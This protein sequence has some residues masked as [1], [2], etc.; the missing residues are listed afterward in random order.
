MT[1]LPLSGLTII[2]LSRVL[3]GPYCSMM[4]ADLG[5]RIIKVEQPGKGDDTRTYGPFSAS[6][7]SGYFTSINRG[8][9]SIALDLKNPDDRAVL[10]A[11]LA[12]ADVLL[13]NFRPG[14]MEKLGLGWG[15]LHARFPRLIY[16][17][18]SGFGHSGPDSQKAAYDVVAQGLSG[19]M[20]ITGHPG[21][22][23]T[24]VGTSIGDISAGMFACSGVL[25]AL[26][27][28]HKSGQG[29][30]VDVAMLDGQIAVLESAI[31]RYM[32]TGTSPTPLGTH[33][34]GITP[35]GAFAC[36]D[37]HIIIAA[38]N[39]ELWQCL[40][41]ALGQPQ[42]IND[43]KL[44]SNP[45]R[46][47]D[48]LAVAAL[49]ESVLSTNSRA[50][51]LAVLAKAGVPCAPINSVAEAVAMPQVQA[52]NMIVNTAF[53]DGTRLRIAGSPIKFS[54]CPDAL[55][56]P[57][58]AKLNEHGAAIRASLKAPEAALDTNF[59]RLTH[60]LADVAGT[61]VRRYFRQPCAVDHKADQ[62]PVTVADRQIEE[63]LRRILEAEWPS[64]GIIGEE[65]GAVRA[66]ADYVWVIDPIDGTR[67]FMSGKPT[68]G[69]LIALLHKGVPVLGLIDQPIVGDRWIGAQGHA[70]HHNGS[71]ATSRA[72]A[73]LAHATIATTGPS[74]FNDDERRA[75]ERVR[76]AGRTGLWGG[77]C[78]NYGLLASG[79]IDVVIE[80]GLKL[81]DFAALVPV[82]NG[83]GGLMCDW[84]GAPLTAKS[85]DQVIALGDAA[86][87]P[88]VRELLLKTG[89]AE[90]D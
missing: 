24:R 89:A 60:R 90:K 84:Q 3:A 72:C 47:S 25:A 77:D 75:Y 55:T 85:F 62:S 52:R 39:D 41:G 53:E 73:V 69:T 12:T 14:V 1:A 80:S 33:H 76:V 40:A 34:P 82:V 45:A 63:A 5:A 11:L 81:H 36:S 50:H 15:A 9:E 26:L 56:R 31:T 67:S 83:A 71:P 19:M 29:Q 79:H 61:I 35:F 6:G 17:A 16:C 18:V 74:Y 65:Y 54:A 43:P 4:L 44:A 86:L 28:R 22:P 88:Q 58:A 37:G 42:W 20:S 7:K 70:T 59:L 68:F 64:H 13:E 49:L 87:L 10:D 66:D 48:I 2:D 30:L 78:Y 32:V 8:K 27:H 23:P 51:W 38:G 46:N 57:R 21:G